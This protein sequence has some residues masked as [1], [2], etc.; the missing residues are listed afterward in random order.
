M[1]KDSFITSYGFTSSI[2]VT[3]VGIGIFSYPREVASL[4]GGD[5]WA[6]TIGAGILNLLLLRF[7]IKALKVNNF[8][9]ITD[10]VKGN[11]GSVFGGIIMLLMIIPNIIAISLGMRAFVEVVKMYLL[12]KT[13]TEFIILV[14]ILVGI[15]IVRGGIRSNVKFNEVTLWIMFIPMIVIL[16]F[17]L[18]MADLS[19]I[20]PVFRNKP[21]NYV[22]ALI[23]AMFSFG[24]VEVVYLTAPLLKNKEKAYRNIVKSMIFVIGFYILVSI[25]CIAVFTT[26][27]NNKLL[28]PTIAMVRSIEIPGSFIERWDGVVMALWI[29]FYFTT[30]SNSFTFSSYIL[31]D[32]VPL[33]DIRLST[34]V[35]A[36]FIYIIAM[37]PTNISELYSAMHSV[38]PFNMII[39][40][41][42]LPFIL[43]ITR[44]KGVSDKEGVK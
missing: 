23:G 34:M 19:N 2:I 30:F 11:L 42:A 35:I 37:A 24:G 13:P 25:L 27:E 3:V 12:E 33:K 38:V 28:W 4:V 10:I 43:I 29:L 41:V 22:S 8:R 6:I 1:K 9:R 39:N 16:L 15:Y 26:S 7:V 44:R 18:K 14:T 5:V 20:L 36:P 17:A 40:L 31:S 32:A 21:N